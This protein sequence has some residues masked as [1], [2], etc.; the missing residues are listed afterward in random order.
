M[1]P[2]DA[3]IVVADRLSFALIV[4]IRLVVLQA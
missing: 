4:P 3:I 2:R 1:N